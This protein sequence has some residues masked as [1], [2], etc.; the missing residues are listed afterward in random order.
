[1]TVSK[2][3]K[4]FSYW[5]K[6][7]I[8]SD[9]LQHLST[10]LF[11]TETPLTIQELSKVLVLHRQEQIKKH[12]ASL[13]AEAGLPYQ[14]KNTYQV[15]DK[16][17]FPELTMRLELLSPYVRVSTAMPPFQVAEIELKMARSANLPLS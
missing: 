3:N 16:I 13:E 17:R 5:E 4:K 6:L 11:E 7:D 15:A 1:M 14:P 10:Y 2:N 12:E 9:D 8:V